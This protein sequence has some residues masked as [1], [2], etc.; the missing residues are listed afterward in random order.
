VAHDHAVLFSSS[1]APFHGSSLRS[2]TP[3]ARHLRSTV[4]RNS[5][6]TPLTSVNASILTSLSIKDL[7]ELVRPALIGEYPSQEDS[8]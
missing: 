1:A 3:P 4:G 2:W 6:W 5:D 8:C 7:V